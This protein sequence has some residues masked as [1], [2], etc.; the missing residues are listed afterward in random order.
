MEGETDVKELK[1]SSDG[2]VILSGSKYGSETGAYRAED[3]YLSMSGSLAGFFVDYENI[4]GDYTIKGNTLT[5]TNVNDGEG[6]TKTLVYK[7]KK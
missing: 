1:F 2:A 3:G 5:I 6:G 7:R 4:Y